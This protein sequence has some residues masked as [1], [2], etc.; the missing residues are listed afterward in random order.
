MSITSKNFIETDLKGKEFEKDVLALFQNNTKYG[1]KFET[2]NFSKKGE[3]YQ[4]DAIVVWEE[5]IFIFEVK[6]RSISNCRTSN[7]INL[8]S[9]LEDYLNQTLR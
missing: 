6:N 5:Y 8:D 7:L 9:K 2:F 3:D 4:Y 1:L